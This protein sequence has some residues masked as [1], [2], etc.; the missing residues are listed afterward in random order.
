MHIRILSRDFFAFEGALV[1]IPYLIH[2]F[3][4]KYLITLAYI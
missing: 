1:I 3:F 4:S 2:R